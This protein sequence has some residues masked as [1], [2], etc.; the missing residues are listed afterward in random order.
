MVVSLLPDDIC[1]CT[2]MYRLV[3]HKDSLVMVETPLITNVAD[4][5]LNFKLNV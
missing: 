2:Y 5:C 1:T 4:G 3:D